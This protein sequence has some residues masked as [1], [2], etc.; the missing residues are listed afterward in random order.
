MIWG[1]ASWVSSR[2]VMAYETTKR[3]SVGEDGVGV[4][5]AE[6][7]SHLHTHHLLSTSLQPASYYPQ[8][9]TTITIIITNGEHHHTAPLHAIITRHPPRPT[10]IPRHN[11]PPHPVLLPSPPP[12][13]IP[14]QY[15][16][17]VR[18]DSKRV[19]LHHLSTSPLPTIITRFHFA[20]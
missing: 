8:H 12:T 18:K 2:E 15:V 9:F 3:R 7:Q 1:P 11:S 13:N 14:C 5:A 4:T 20:H 10:N 17:F 19:L 16:S 6:H